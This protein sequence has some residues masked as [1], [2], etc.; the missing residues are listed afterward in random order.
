MLMAKLAFIKP[1]SILQLVVTGFALVSG[2]LLVALTITIQQLELISLQSQTAVSRSISAMAASRILLEQSAAMERN[3]RQYSIVGED[4]ILAVYNERRGAFLGAAESLQE[5]ALNPELLDQIARVR[6]HETDAYAAIEVGDNVSVEASFDQVLEAAANLSTIVTDWANQQIDAIAT[7]ESDSKRLITLQLLMLIAAA[8]FLA[9]VFV[10][11]IIRPLKQVALAIDQL[12]S[13][14]YT[15]TVNVDG[16]RDLVVIGQQLDWLRT[17]LSHLEQQRTL[18]LRHVSHELK[19]PLATI[20]E[21]AAL[22]GDGV[23]GELSNSQQ[24]LIDIQV[25]SLHKLHALID[26]L[27]RQHELHYAVVS[28]FGQEIR[29]DRLVKEILSDH[30]YSIGTSGIDVSLTLEKCKINGNREQLRVLLDNVIVNAIRF[31]PERG[32]LAIDLHREG[33]NC[34]IVVKDEGPGVCASELDRIFEAFYQGQQ[35]VDSVF[36]GSGLGLAIAREYAKT[37]GGKVEVVTSES[38]GACFRII[39]PITRPTAVI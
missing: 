19:S 35:Q 28:D 8:I 36:K 4:E 2:I 25:K 10:L 29:I 20:Q 15:D 33:E 16:P 39:L 24:E 13:G 30:D 32:K 37:H 18:F 14:T 11:L 26:D 6:A 21:S 38:S 31:S 1:R 22:L 5:L 23:V 17:R 12:G 3:A 34:V 9:S 7:E 27:L